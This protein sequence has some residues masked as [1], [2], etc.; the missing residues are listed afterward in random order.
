M[1]RG[2]ATLLSPSFPFLHAKI[3]F[4]QELKDVAT[5]HQHVTCCYSN[6]AA[7]AEKIYHLPENCVSRSFNTKMAGVL[8]EERLEAMRERFYSSD[9]NRLAQNVCSRSDP[10]E[11]CLNR[12]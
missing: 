12:R 3:T 5:A 10:L 7:I 8:S 9:K 4:R 1:T 11:A 6:I 2:Y